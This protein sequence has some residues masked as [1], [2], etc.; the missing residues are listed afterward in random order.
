MDRVFFLGILLQ[1]IVKMNKEV[2]RDS[3]FEENQNKRNSLSLTFFQS[4][5]L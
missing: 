3:E 2:Y 1:I 4:N 5:I